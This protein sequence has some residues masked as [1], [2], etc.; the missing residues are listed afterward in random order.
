MESR[1]G[2]SAERSADGAVLRRPIDGCPWRTNAGADQHV[3]GEGGGRKWL[4]DKDIQHHNKSA[5]HAGGH[6]AGCNIQVRHGWFVL[7]SESLCK[8]WI[9]SVPLG[10]HGGTAAS[11]PAGNQGI[12]REPDRRN[13]DDAG[14]V[15]V[16]FDGDGQ[17]RGE[18]LAADQHHHHLSRNGESPA[19]RDSPS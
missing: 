9:S 4:R 1:C 5:K 14:N 11:R 6:S 17:L 15:H 18:G 7:F 2:L 19:A 12:E 8:W 3:H 16:H 10:S 13:P